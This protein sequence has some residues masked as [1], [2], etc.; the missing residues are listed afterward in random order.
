MLVFGRVIGLPASKF[1]QW[2]E[3]EIDRD[4]GITKLF[5]HRAFKRWLREIHTI[6]GSKGRLLG[7]YDGDKIANFNL[8]W[9]A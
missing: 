4:I 2:G 6:V 1:Y 7:N 8:V 9:S 5:R 3:I